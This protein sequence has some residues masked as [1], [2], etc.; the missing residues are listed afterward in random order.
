MRWATAL[1]GLVVVAELAYL[2][3]FNVMLPPEK[4][5]PPRPPAVAALQAGS[6]TDG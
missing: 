2:R 1:V 5:Y 4:A 3:G 6:A